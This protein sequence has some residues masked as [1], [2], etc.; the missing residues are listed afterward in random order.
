VLLSPV[1]SVDPAFDLATAVRARSW[2][3]L[4]QIGSSLDVD[5]RIVDL[6]TAPVLSPPSAAA[7]AALRAPEFVAAV[8]RAQRAQSIETLQIGRTLVACVV[9]R[10]AGSDSGV[11]ALSRRVS[12]KPPAHAEQWRLEQVASFLR[13]AIEAHL[14]SEIERSGEDGQRLA[15]LRR[16]LDDCEAGSEIDLLRVFGDAVGIWEDVE[17]RAYTEAVNGEYIQQW[18]PAGAADDQIPAVLASLAGL[19]TRELSRVPAQSLDQLGIGS[20]E[21]IVVAQIA[22]D[23]SRWMLVFTQSVDPACLNRLSLYV[24]ILE[25]SLKRLAISTTLR[26][27][28]NVWDRLLAADESPARAGEA[29]L[30]EIVRGICGDF[31]A[32]LVT[33]PHG[34]RAVAAGA[35]DRFAD[36]QAP[37]SESQLAM[38]RVLET[39]GTLVIAVGR[40]EGR[41]S[42]SSGERDLLE[43]MADM[44]ESWAAAIVRR[45]AVVGERRAAARPFQQVVEELAQ[46]TLRNGNSVSVVVIRLA[47]GE[48]R[49]GAAHRLAAQIRAHLRAAEPAGALTDGEIAAVLLD[50]NRDQARAVI[51]RLRG[52]GPTLDEG[53]ALA[54]AAMGV[55]HC[56]PGSVYDMPLV[57][58]AREDALRSANDASP[59]GH[60]Q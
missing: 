36:L 39:G 14:E 26:L 20:R 28:R 32:L 12:A 48:A 50:T 45:P 52:L 15:A 38:T 34:G 31:A 25:Q 13:P 56:A 30:Q 43:S 27:S 57:L 2:T 42:F 16:A 37:A 55:A 53:E 47:G 7:S 40:K 44:L 22:P 4:F 8:G 6:R 35:V 3:W 58:A 9:L 46:Q 60:I 18:A 21:E 23:G 1:N 51:S 29:A 10:V 49:P 33:F 5:V 11:L 54:S 17:V 59:G 19:Q 41:A 24:D